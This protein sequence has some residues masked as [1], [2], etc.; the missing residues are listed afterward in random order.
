LA[1]S[2][3]V[4]SNALSLARRGVPTE[5]AVARLV[6]DAEGRRAALVV[7]RELLLDEVARHGGDSRYPRAIELLNKALART[8]WPPTPWK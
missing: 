4:R 8:T 6:A 2:G 3:T 5:K 1:T 7:A